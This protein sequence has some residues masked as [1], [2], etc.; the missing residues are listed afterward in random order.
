VQPE[1]VDAD[2]LCAIELQAC[3]CPN[4]D[5]V[6]AT[7]E[8]GSTTAAK[9]ALANDLDNESD[10]AAR[11]VLPARIEPSICSRSCG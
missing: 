9:F 11:K 2:I 4:S 1:P 10:L 6:G 3:G 8:S 5:A 7:G